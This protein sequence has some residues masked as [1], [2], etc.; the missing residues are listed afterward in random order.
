MD[1]AKQV[2]GGMSSMFISERKK[3]EEILQI[4]EEQYRGIFESSIDALIIVG[5]NGLFVDANSA[6]CR[7]FGYSSEELIGLSGEFIVPPDYFTRFEEQRAR[8]EKLNGKFK[9]EAIIICKDGTNIDTQIQ[10]IRISFQ[11]KPHIVISVRDITEFKIVYNRMM[12]SENMAVRGQ[13]AASV[14]H[15][16]NSPLQGIIAILDTLQK[17]HGKDSKIIQSIT[18]LK[19]AFS[20][21]NIAANSI[22]ELNSQPVDSV[23]PVNV[24][25]LIKSTVELIGGYLNLKRVKTNLKL[26]SRISVIN[27]SPSKLMHVFVNLINNAV[28]SIS[29]AHEYGLSNGEGEITLN[30]N[31]KLGNIIV[32][33]SDTGIGISRDDLED[34]FNPLYTSKKT[35][36]KGMGLLI[37]RNIIEELGGSIQADNLPE[38]GAALTI[39]L[40]AAPHSTP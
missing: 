36:G 23:Q 2:K 24:N 20:S 28:D 22:L 21:I 30:S 15:K 31:L 39:V 7:M 13:M 12:L 33:I 3:V 4:Y 29:A 6:A 34:I 27:A 19:N 25:D 17:E 32:K 37:C 11:G 5:P 16:I 35:A 1:K 14:A 8:V 40:P 9:T 38:G 26:S 10:G 18:P